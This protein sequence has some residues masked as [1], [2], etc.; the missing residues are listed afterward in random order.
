M[1]PIILMEISIPVTMENHL[2][3]PYNRPNGPNAQPDSPMRHR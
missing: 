2:K 1:E 3:S